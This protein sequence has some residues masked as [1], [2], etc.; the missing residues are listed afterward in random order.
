MQGSHDNEVLRE[1]ADVR[2]DLA[3]LTNTVERLVKSIEGNGKPGLLDRVSSLELH[4]KTAL[5]W[6]GGA[7]F[8]LN[9]LTGDGALTLAGLL[10]YVHSAPPK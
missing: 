7:L 2:S 5:A 10:R 4:R 8:V 3:V 6:V 1:I 9:F